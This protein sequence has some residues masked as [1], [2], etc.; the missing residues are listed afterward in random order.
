MHGSSFKSMSR[1]YFAMEAETGT[2]IY[3]DYKF[4]LEMQA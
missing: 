4:Q 2:T 3:W 1:D